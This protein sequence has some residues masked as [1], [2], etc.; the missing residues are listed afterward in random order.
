MACPINEEDI[1]KLKKFIEIVSAQPQVLNLPMLD[2]FKNFVESLGG[3]VPEFASKFEGF[4]HSRLDCVFSYH[5]L[6]V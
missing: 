1:S 5:N 2:F 3:K 6:N 4:E